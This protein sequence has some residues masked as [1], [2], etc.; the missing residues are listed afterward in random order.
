MSETRLREPG[1]DLRAITEQLVCET[2]ADALSPW[3]KPWT[4]A[5]DP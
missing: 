3:Q 1:T 4:V 5:L 2:I